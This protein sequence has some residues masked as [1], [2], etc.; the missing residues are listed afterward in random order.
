MHTLKQ[1]NRLQLLCASLHLEVCP[2]DAISGK[3]I[4][5]H[6]YTIAETLMPHPQP[7]HCLFP[8]K[9]SVPPFIFALNVGFQTRPPTQ[10]LLTHASH[11]RIRGWQVRDYELMGQCCLLNGVRT[12]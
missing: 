7:A 10:I 4:A 3:E 2:V 5:P 8:T 6:V 12:L 11:S 1:V 9:E